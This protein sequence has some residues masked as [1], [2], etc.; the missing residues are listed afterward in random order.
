M[1]NIFLDVDL[2]SAYKV[3][4]RFYSQVLAKCNQRLYS[5]KKKI[6][7]SSRWKTLKIQGPVAKI[8]QKYAINKE[9]IKRMINAI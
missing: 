2:L 7:F 1:L 3:L 6:F 4:D 9:E 8:H 5:L